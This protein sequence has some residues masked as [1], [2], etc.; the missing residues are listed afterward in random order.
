MARLFPFPLK[1]KVA[2]SGGKHPSK[3][4]FALRA[5]N[6]VLE[7]Q[8]EA[9]KSE[10]VA[11]KQSVSLAVGSPADNRIIGPHL[12]ITFNA[13]GMVT[14]HNCDFMND[15]KFQKAY[16]AGI[17]TKHNFGADLQIE[18]RIF[19]ACWAAHHATLIEG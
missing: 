4:V 11:L 1:R 2:S 17:E 14:V 12:P 19:V 7:D 8:I 6:S 9:L 5:R 16:K 13:D 3:E 18:W 15:P 10:V